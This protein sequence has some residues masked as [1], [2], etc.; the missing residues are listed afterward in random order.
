M[1]SCIFLS[2]WALEYV[3][4]YFFRNLIVIMLHCP[5]YL[6]FSC[7][8]IF[9]NDFD[10]LQVRKLLAS[11][12][13]S[14]IWKYMYGLYV[15]RNIWLYLPAVYSSCTVFLNHILYMLL[16]YC[17]QLVLNTIFL[18]NL[19]FLFLFQCFMASSSYNTCSASVA[20]ILKR[21]KKIWTSR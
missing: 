20:G 19:S 3:L 1:H 11:K 12:I 8:V 17:K 18:S 5:K 15:V 7:M 6:T 2:F 14:N 21:E 9:F 13:K 16:K 4:L 10:I